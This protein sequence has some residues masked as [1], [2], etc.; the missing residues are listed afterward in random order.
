MSLILDF[1]FPKFCLA[2]KKPGD[3]FCP[4]CLDK[5][6]INSPRLSKKD[7]NYEGSL[8]L[9]KYNSLIKQL[10]NEIKYG[11]VTDI[12]DPFVDLIASVLKNNF[13]HLLDYWRQNNFVIVPIP[14]HYFRQNWRGFNQSVLI[15]QKLA[16]NLDLKFSD[17]ILFRSKNTRVQAK[18]TQKSVKK[19]NLENAFICP[20]QPLPQNIIIFDDVAT[21]FST[22]RSAL[23][24][25]SKPGVLNHCW[26]LTLAGH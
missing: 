14:L 8:S 1:I 20:N 16:Q 21:T 12:I 24:T 23:K 5:Q 6:L 26:F 9:F 11:F 13:P 3:Y 10:I 4:N 2:C 15:G 18:L 19:S 7:L 22:L 17:Q 25:I